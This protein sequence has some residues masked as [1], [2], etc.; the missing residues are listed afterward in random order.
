M[1]RKAQL[2]LGGVV[3]ALLVILIVQNR[4]I[5]VFRVFFW[6]IAISQVILV[7]LLALAGFLVGLMAAALGR[8]RRDRF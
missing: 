7:P 8:R 2:I 4:A 6:T 5:V 1:N 3:L